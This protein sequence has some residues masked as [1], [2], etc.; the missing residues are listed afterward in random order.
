MDGKYNDD[1]KQSEHGSNRATAIK[2]LG[3]K[4]LRPSNHEVLTNIEKV[5]NTIN[6]SITDN[7]TKNKDSQS[8]H[9]L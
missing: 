6:Q 8:L 3:I 4:V 2:R 5:I 7:K 1:K 9:H